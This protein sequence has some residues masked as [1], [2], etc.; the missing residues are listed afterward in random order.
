MQVQKGPSWLMD[1]NP[2]PLSCEANSANTAQYWRITFFK[3]QIKYLN[4]TYI[5]LA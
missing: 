1:L 3:D 5:R 2:G 4:K